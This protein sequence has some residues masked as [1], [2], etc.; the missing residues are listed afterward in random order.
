MRT[1]INRVGL[2]ICWHIRRLLV[3]L[4]LWRVGR[5]TNGLLNAQDWVA[6]ELANEMCKQADG[7]KAYAA[8]SAAIRA[9][10]RGNP[11]DKS[12]EVTV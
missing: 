5:N 6:R 9:L 10:K 11:S 7:S 1:E 8:A 3:L 4:A 12:N 2:L